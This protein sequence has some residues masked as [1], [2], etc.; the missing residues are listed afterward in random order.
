MGEEKRVQMIVR[1]P[2]SLKK[3]LEKEARLTCMSL[4][5]YVI[6]LLKNRKVG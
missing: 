4:T 5:S 3:G 2:L 6:Q 1:V